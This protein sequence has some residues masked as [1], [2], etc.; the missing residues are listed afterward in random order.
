MMLPQMKILGM[1][2][3]ELKSRRTRKQKGNLI[4]GV[5]A[6]PGSVTAPACVVHG[7][8]DFSKMKPGDILVAA[9][10]TPA[11]TPLFARAAGVVTDVGGSLSHGSSVA[12]EYGI[13]AVLG[14][15]VAS[16]RIRDGQKISVDGTS[17]TVLL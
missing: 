16:Q 14:T 17:G 7:P 8:E 15:G 5:A 6:S 13:P 9:I 3:S 11:W 12:R 10:T 4:K 2:L 1:D